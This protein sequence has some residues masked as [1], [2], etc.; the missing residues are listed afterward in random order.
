MAKETAKERKEREEAASELLFAKTK[1]EYPK[2][3]MRAMAN[4]AALP[5]FSFTA[6]LTLEDNYAFS[7]PEDIS[8]WDARFL[9][10]AEM[11]EWEDFYN[12]ETVESYVFKYAEARAEE[13]RKYE[14]RKAALAKLSKEERELLGI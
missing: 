11:K 9:L 4:Y 6:D 12:L 3:L 5:D 10:P 2:R 7:P 8:W 13:E 1:A 14:M